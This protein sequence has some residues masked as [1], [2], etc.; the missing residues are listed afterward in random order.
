MN[1]T[2]LFVTIACFLIFGY[3]Y[4]SICMLKKQKTKITELE[5]DLKEAISERD[6]LSEEIKS[7]SKSIEK[8]QE[9]ENETKQ[10]LANIAS[11]TT[12]DSVARLQ[13]P[14]KRRKAKSSKNSNT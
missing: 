1:F 11:G 5:M 14:E 9:I 13:H 7:L 3:V 6:V 12:D 8:K 4:I 2:I 10:N